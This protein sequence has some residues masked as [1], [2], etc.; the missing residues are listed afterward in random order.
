MV[1]DGEVPGKPN[2][3]IDVDSMHLEDI[4]DFF[5]KRNIEFPELDNI[6]E[7]RDKIRSLIKE[8]DDIKTVSITFNIH[9]C[10]L[11]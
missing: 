9:T 7:M 10:V 2:D 6:E 8:A 3:F 1:I 5:E 4:Y 11:H